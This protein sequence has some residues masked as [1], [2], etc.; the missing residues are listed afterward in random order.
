MAFVDRE[1]ACMD[2][3]QSF[4]FTAGEQEFYERKG[5]KEEPKRCK[6]C[7]EARKQRRNDA[8]VAG[9]PGRP[10]APPSGGFGF[11]GQPDRG[12]DDERGNRA[13]NLDERDDDFGNRAPAPRGARGGPPP[14]AAS[15]DRGGGRELFDA[16]CA[17]CSAPAK[18]P[19]RP[20][21][22]RPVYCRDCFAARA[23]AGGR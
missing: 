2:C 1:I 16:T 17:Q 5:F 22:G 3:S 19:F 14:R 18:V 11:R 6:P 21:P 13:T 10:E 7:R 23:A 8:P 12:D 20:A 9:R 4:V 15:N